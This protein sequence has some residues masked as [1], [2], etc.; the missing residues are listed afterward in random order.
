M[1]DRRALVATS[2]AAVALPVW[3]VWGASGRMHFSV[4]RNGRP[5]GSHRLSFDETGGRRTIDIAIDLAVKF[6]FV[7]V[8]SYRHRNREVWEGGE[9]VSFTSETDDNG[10]RLRASARREGEAIRVQGSGGAAEVPLGLP[11]T[12]WW[13]RAVTESNRLIDTQHGR[14]LDVAWRAL[15]PA[16]VPVAGRPVQADGFALT[17]DH[18]LEIWFAGPLWVK[19]AFAGP[20]GSRL[21]YTLEEAPDPRLVSLG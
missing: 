7:T 16:T 1:L 12:T 8:Y 21:E 3:P 19:L 2:L 14:I 5:I 15:A 20:D 18:A 4:A 17:G 6:A 10:Q 9:F 13:N 11:P